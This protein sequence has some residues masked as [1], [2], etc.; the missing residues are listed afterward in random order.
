MQQT[1]RFD[2]AVSFLRA[3]RLDDAESVCQEILRSAPTHDFSL[4][5]LGIVALRQ[6]RPELAQAFLEKALAQDPDNSAYHVNL[7]KIFN[8][9]ARS[10]ESESHFR[11][12]LRL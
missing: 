6:G 7:A 5:L 2:E 8:V 10:S 3:G 4:N 9:L 1:A 11:E 12:G